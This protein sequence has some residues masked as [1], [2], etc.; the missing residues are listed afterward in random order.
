MLCSGVAGV[1]IIL[2]VAMASAQER[3]TAVPAEREGVQI[4]NPVAGRIVV[5]SSRPDGARVEKGEVICELDSAELQDRLASDQVALQGTEAEVRG[6]SLAREVAVMALNEYKEGLFIRDLVTAEADIKLAESNLAHAEDSLDWTRRMF[7]KGYVSMA[8]KASEELT[9]KKARFAIEEAQNKRKVLID[10]TKNRTVKALLGAVETAR[11]RELREQSVLERQRAALKRLDSQIRRCKVAA[12][13]VGRVRY[14][15][16]IGAGAVL[17]DGQL[18][19][20]IVP[21]GEARTPAN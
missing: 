10:Y 21:E 20:R 1:P 5:V 7:D 15:S 19:C 14:A 3:Q 2:A 11:A 8:T 9:F 4:F 16:P 6:A 13:V 18:L 17:R 12:P